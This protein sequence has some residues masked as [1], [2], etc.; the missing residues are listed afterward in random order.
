MSKY[1][2]KK[3]I[4]KKFND[5]LMDTPTAQAY[6][7]GL[8]VG[9]LEAYRSCRTTFGKKTTEEI[10]RDCLKGNDEFSTIFRTLVELDDK[11]NQSTAERIAEALENSKRS[12]EKLSDDDR[13]FLEEFMEFLYKKEKSK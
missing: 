1:T 2:T 3:Y 4:E 11:E 6:K 10:Y 9:L 8:A 5:I 13:D 12:D 7:L